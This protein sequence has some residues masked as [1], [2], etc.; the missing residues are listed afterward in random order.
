MNPFKILLICAF[1]AGVLSI[2]GV[3]LSQLYSASV[4]ECFKK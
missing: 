2:K 3:D 1:F 4:Y